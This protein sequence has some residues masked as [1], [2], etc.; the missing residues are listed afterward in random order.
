[1]S[2]FALFRYGIEINGDGNV[3]TNNL[4]AGGLS[5]GIYITGSNNTIGGTSQ[6]AGNVIRSRGNGIWIRPAW[7]ATP[8]SA[9]GNVVQGNLIT[10]NRNDGIS[11]DDGTSGNL[12]G[13]T[14]AAARNVINSNG[15][16]SSEYHPVGADVAVGGSGNVVQ[17]NAIGVDA[18]GTQ[19]RGGVVASGVAVSGTG[20][21][22]GGTQP[23][24]GN[25]ISGHGYIS[26]QLNG[27]PA[28]IRIQTGTDATIQGNLIGTDA[29][30]TQPLPN[31]IGIH[32]PEGL[33]GRTASNVTIGGADTGAANVIAFN[34]MDGIAIK[35][36]FSVA[37]NGI[38]ISRNSIHS[39]GELGIDLADNPG[40]E[41]YP[42]SVTPNDPG[43]VDIGAN[44]LQNFPLITAI[45]ED[46]SST[47]VEGTLDT[48]SPETV[49]VELFSSRAVDPS[50]FGEGETF[51]TA[52]LPDA[53]GRFTAILVGGLSGQFVT[54]TATDAQGNT[55]EFSR[56]LRVGDQPPVNQPPVAVADGRPYDVNWPLTATFDST[57]SHD[58]DGTIVLRVWDL[59]DGTVT[60]GANPIWT[61][62]APGTYTATLTVTDDEGATDTDTVTVT[63][64]DQ[65][66]VNQPPVAVAAAAPHQGSAP[67]TVTFDSTGSHDP[68]GTI[69]SRRWDLGDGTVAADANPT[70][71]YSSP[72]SY[73]ATLTVIDDDGATDTA[74]VTVTVESDSATILMVVDIEL[75]GRQHR[76][77]TTVDGQI[78]I[79]TR[80]GAKVRD[81]SVSVTW[82]LPNGGR[83]GQAATTT[84]NGTAH[85]E[86][87]GGA[88]AYTLTVTDVSKAEHALD[89][90]NSQLEASITP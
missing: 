12:V 89:R 81:A 52:T 56:A 27:R 37:P 82:T 65:P 6:D 32:V 83:Q 78:A 7:D 3:V 49:T 30:G 5:A 20:N 50:G 79:V 55:S 73:T 88:G 76:G 84:A 24:A 8:P 21:I 39:N 28:G 75:K 42:A 54:A 31:Q 9:T 11:I 66:P 1:M 68:D 69:V 70:H 47:V 34:H 87:S 86:I 60:T 59:G 19:A 15:H 67:L 16:L 46:G 14:T 10:S 13:G 44:G 64:G 45:R 18:S 90:A 25:I 33:F 85:F 22:I 61:Y 57:G 38:T 26:P 29:T 53:A 77:V 51:Q 41:Q 80:D 4:L 2:G 62:A 35:G 58:P 48:P 17:G 40:V 74:M 43:D 72:G 36:T 71:T 23:G 63:V